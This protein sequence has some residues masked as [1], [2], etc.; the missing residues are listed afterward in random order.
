MALLRPRYGDEA[1]R[2]D[3]LNKEM[4]EAFL[5]GEAFVL[6]TRRPQ[7]GRDRMPMGQICYL[8]WIAD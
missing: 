2:A 1:A 3:R 5:V 8:N 7:L 6:T 4:D